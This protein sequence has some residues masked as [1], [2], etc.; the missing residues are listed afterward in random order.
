MAETC[1]TPAGGKSFLFGLELRTLSAVVLLL[2]STPLLLVLV[3]PTVVNRFG[4][5]LGYTLRKKTEG[6]RAQLIAVMHEED[7]KYWKEN[8][9]PKTSPSAGWEAVEG[10]TD[11]KSGSTGV[12]S[13][14]DWDGIIGFFH[15][16]W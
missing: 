14:K 6:R 11:E 12:Q 1:M 3:A 16:F 5:F 9:R 8:A 13:Q 2:A 4:R 10:E 15:P 7:E